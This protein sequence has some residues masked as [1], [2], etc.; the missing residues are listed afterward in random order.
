MISRN[1]YQGRLPYAEYIKRFQSAQDLNK[2]LRA[3]VKKELDSQIAQGKNTISDKFKKEME[4]RGI[5][6]SKLEQV[7]DMLKGQGSL[8]ENKRNA[9][10]TGFLLAKAGKPSRTSLTEQETTRAQSIEASKLAYLHDDNFQTAQEHLDSI[11][12]EG[13]GV[14]DRDL[15]STDSIVIRKPNGKVEI[16]YRGTQLTGKP[17]LEDLYTDANVAL[18][19][20][21]TTAQFERANAQLKAAIEKYGL[22]N[23]D[24]LTGYSLGGTKALTL[25]QANNIESTTFNPF[26][27]K[28]LARGIN[29][30][31]AQHKIIRTTT[32]AASVGLMVSADRNHANW[33][34]HSIRPLA[35]NE[36]LIPLLETYDGHRLNN[37]T[38]NKGRGVNDTAIERLSKQNHET[39]TLLVR[40]DL[41]H[42]TAN[43]KEEGK[44]FSEA[45][46][47]LQKNSKG[48]TVESRNGIDNVDIMAGPDGKPILK[49][50]GRHSVQSDMVRS[51]RAL[52]GE[53]TEHEA[54]V[55]AD[56]A[57][58]DKAS[59]TPAQENLR[60]RLK[61]SRQ[62]E[63][64]NIPENLMIKINGENVSSKKIA[65][66]KLNEDYPVDNDINPQERL[67]KAF[68]KYDDSG[69]G[70]TGG[71]KAE[72]GFPNVN[73]SESDNETESFINS[74][75]DQRIKEMGD[76]NNKYQQDQTT[77]TEAFEPHEAAGLNEHLR[78]LSATHLGIGA[79]IGLL[80]DTT[81]NFIDPNDK[82]QGKIQGWERDALSGGV[83]GATTAAAATTLGLGEMALGPEVVAG[84]AGYI[85]AD[86]G[87]QG[88]AL[89]AKAA[90]GGKEVQEASADISGGLAGGLGGY[91]A[92]G[93]IAAG[94]D[95]LFGGELGATFGPGGAA[96]GMAIGAGIGLAAF[97][98]SSLK[99]AIKSWF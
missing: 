39:L 98:Y 77:L 50:G 70:R 90:G 29:T 34:I 14:I 75:K 94:S 38:S 80:T 91:V 8:D 87:A 27:G 59:R 92:G 16:A 62:Q 71:N 41:Q 5:D 74:S 10:Y 93:L 17:S 22:A 56:T 68:K 1:N 48:E 85:A 66:Q 7:A 19:T 33:D 9:L 26:I 88:G 58:I 81:L 54:T 72:F 3:N 78:G 53:F 86:Y 21:R 61:T 51:W 13:A 97:G 64:D 43:L 63:I 28:R 83:A 52:G 55:I 24:H 95:A 76:L 6:T 46:A 89:L 25:G 67:Q 40:K 20:D 96:V 45:V 73:Y 47:D 44:T 82:G 2:D 4:E 69:I 37:F 49:P 18:G 84:A 57:N 32:D 79:A 65:Q 30:T 11:S 15:S 99:T 35:E 60:N 12:M 42:K 23:I 36:H 31:D